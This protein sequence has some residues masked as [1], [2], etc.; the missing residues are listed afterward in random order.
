MQEETK[1]SHCS[2][3]RYRDSMSLADLG[4]KR[5]GENRHRSCVG[6]CGYC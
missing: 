1:Y 4:K 6:D 5:L 3:T 2:E